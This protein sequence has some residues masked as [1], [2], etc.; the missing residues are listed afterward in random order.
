[1]IELITEITNWNKNLSEK[2][3]KTKYCKMGESPFYFFRGTNHYFWKF[4]CSDER[5]K[6]FKNTKTRTWIQGDL[7]PYNFGMYDNDKGEIVYALNDFDEALVADYQFDLLRIMSSFHLLF[8]E[9]LLTEERDKIAISKAFVFNYLKTINRLIDNDEIENVN[10]TQKNTYGKLKD[11]LKK[12]KKKNSRMKMLEKWTLI[13]DNKKEFDLSYSKLAPLADVEKEEIKKAFVKYG[14]TLIGKLEYSTEHFKILGI[15]KRI[16]SGTGSLGLP[17]YYILIQ[18]ESQA[19]ENMKILDVKLQGKPSA[20]YAMSLNQQYEYDS[21]FSNEGR[22]HAMAYLA[23]SYRT[24]DYLGWLKFDDRVFSVRERSA[25]KDYLPTGIL[26]SP[27]RFIKLA[28]QWAE[29]LATSHSRAY[30]SFDKKEVKNLT[31]LKENDFFENLYNLSKEF[32]Q[33]TKNDFMEFRNT[34][35]PDECF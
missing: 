22:R 28:E 27:K 23:M 2:N 24:D 26:D 32:A 29:I 20:Y 17:R 31:S 1:M 11:E 21:R 35:V 34:L 3:R 30:A 12:V 33:K 18:G 8:K 14:K 13:E 16:S 5:L 10:F 19:I 6:E 4:F 7:H 15:A 9:N 25:Y